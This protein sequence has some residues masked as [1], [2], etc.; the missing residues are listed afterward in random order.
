M[1]LRVCAENADHGLQSLWPRA[2]P[3]T[4]AGNYHEYRPDHE[5]PND[6]RGTGAQVTL[7]LAGDATWTRT[8]VGT[9]R[10]A[11]SNYLEIHADT[12]GAGFTLWLDN[13]RFDPPIEPLAGD[14]NYDGTV[15][16]PD[17]AILLANYGAAC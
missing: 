16:L 6:A 12:W 5:L 7:P 17:L 13:V 10:L 14:V 3:G 11:G 15:D 2:R 4:D 8:T 9:P 1:S